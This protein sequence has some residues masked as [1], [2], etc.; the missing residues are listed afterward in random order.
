MHLQAGLVW[1]ELV[2]QTS[3]DTW[4]V[5]I[6]PVES[7]FQV[8]LAEVG[9][10]SGEDEESQLC[11][12]CAPTLALGVGQGGW[13]QVRETSCRALGCIC[14]GLPAGRGQISRIE[15]SAAGGS[16]LQGPRSAG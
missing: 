14:Q 15:P 6:K 10:M 4:P 2:Q 8:Q 7:V 1:L 13:V 11:G 16:C 3:S 9:S 12:L 5:G